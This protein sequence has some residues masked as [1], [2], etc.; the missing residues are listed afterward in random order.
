MRNCIILGS[1]R[2]GTS[3]VA[4]TLAHAGYY[5][6]DTLLPPTVGNPKGYFEAREVEAVNDALIRTMLTPTP[7]E[8]WLA[9]LHPIPQQPDFEALEPW[10]K[11]H[12]LALVPPGRIPQRKLIYK[13]EIERL[14]AQ[15][16][17]CFKDPRFC[18]TLPAWRPFLRDT[19]FICVFRE[20]AVTVASILKELSTESYLQG[21][22][23]TPAQVYQMWTYSYR[24][25]L[26]LHRHQGDWLFLHYHQA[27]TAEGLARIEACL[28]IRVDTDFPDARLQRS[29]SDL[30]APPPAQ[31]V[32]QQ[33][34]QLAGYP[35]HA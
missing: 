18:Y 26:E 25:V 4:G 34:C 1:G 10:V 27:L 6:G 9:W 5:M 32:Y 15:T 11:A 28:N 2:S 21:L 23:M 16:P 20:P 29:R 13:A 17:F 12:W 7:R 3:M 19:V 31:R 22:S 14:V 35:S 24:H 30:S 33:L 8:R